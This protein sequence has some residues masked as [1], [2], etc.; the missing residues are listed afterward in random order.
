[1]NISVQAANLSDCRIESKKIDSVARIESKLFCPNWNALV[2]ARPRSDF[3]IQKNVDFSI[4]PCMFPFSFLVGIWRTCISSILLAPFAQRASSC[5]GKCRPAV[6]LSVFV[7]LTW[8]PYITAAGLLQSQRA[9]YID[10][11]CMQGRRLA[12]AAPQ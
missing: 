7:C 2:I 6:R 3:G 9:G 1:L 8:P 12:A 4:L 10:R 5:L 11:C